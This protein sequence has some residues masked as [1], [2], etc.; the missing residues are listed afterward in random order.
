MAEPVKVD[1][2]MHLYESTD[3]GEWWKAGYEIWEYGPK[4]GVRFSRYSGT[5]E[6]AIEAMA[7]AGFSHGIA[8]NLFGMEL[9]K[10]EA[11]W[12]LPA[13]MDGKDRAR[14]IAEIEA[15]MPDRLREL[16]RWLCDALADVPQITPFVAADPWALSP[17]ANA[18]HLREMVERGA[19]GIKIHP[20]VQD[21]S[22][23]DPRMLPVYA[24]CREL[25]LTVLSHTGAARGPDQYAAPSAFAAMLREFPDLTVVLAHLGG[26]KWTETLELARA[27]PAV[28]FDLCEI[29][30]WT[31][32]PNAPTVHQLAEMIQEIGAER[33]VLGTDFPWYDLD[34]TVEL[35]M[36]LPVLS[37]E[38]KEGIL[39]ANAVRIL[40]LSL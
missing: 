8:V 14:A 10:Q 15:T 32:A 34:R 17:E 1:V 30:E 26:G 11:V 18:A 27:F 40:R 36:D 13:T 12:K 29:I 5:V 20:V 2:H 22:P 3:V 16:N 19:R 35:V 24:T 37:E 21:F 7:K 4:E 9:S 25:G 23:A 39:G 31:G 6:D 33:V 38:E 28:A